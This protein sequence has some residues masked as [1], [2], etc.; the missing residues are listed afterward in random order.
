VARQAVLVRH[1]F[2]LRN[3]HHISLL[4]CRRPASEAVSFGVDAPTVQEDSPIC[5]AHKPKRR[6]RLQNVFLDDRGFPD[7]SHDYDTLLHGVDSGPILRKL[8]HPQPN[9]DAPIDPSYHSPFVADKHEAQM[10]AA[11]DLSHL[12]PTL[13]EKLYQIIRDHWSVFD[14]K[15]VFVPVKNYKCAI[16][17]GTARPIAVKNILYGELKIK[18]MWKCIA[19]LAKVGHIRQITDGSWL[20][21]ALLAPKPHQEH[22]KNIEDFVW[23]FRVNYIPLNGVTRVIAYPIPRCDTAVFVEFSMG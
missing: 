19:A 17:T 6:K 4:H 11:M 10:R 5:V 1:R 7:Q 23:R 3:T 20:F 13:Q 21:K 8:K 16:D 15:G 22:V 2:L 9:L 14:E 12:S 18:Y